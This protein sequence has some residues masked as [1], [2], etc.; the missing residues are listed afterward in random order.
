MTFGPSPSGPRSA[1][2]PPLPRRPC[3]DP[4]VAQG[5]IGAAGLA[6]TVT[7][8]R[9]PDCP[10]VWVN[11][12]FERT[13]G[14]RF[15]A[16]VGRN[17]RFLQGPDTD[18]A[19]VEQVRAALLRREPVSVTLLNYRADG[20]T[21]WNELSISAVVDEA[22]ELT[23][24]VGVQ[25]DVTA[26]VTAELD[27]ERHLRVERAAR[28]E[29]E[30]AQARLALL[31]EAT[32][33]LAATL[34]VDEAL[35]RLT[36]LAVPALAD[37]CVVELVDPEGRDHRVLARHADPARAEDL[38]RLE[39]LRAGGMS[40]GA[41]VHA[42][43]GGG[44][45]LLLPDISEAQLARWT[46]DEELRRV[47]RR[48]GFGSA[49]VVPLRARRHVVGTLSLVRRP[50]SPRHDQ[51]DFD[52]AADLARRAALALDNARLYTR[53]RMVAEELQRELL[54][55]LT[56][57]PGLDTAARYLP[58]SESAQV[59]GDW[60][61]LFALP[62]GAA[63][64]AIG[65]VMG[66]D[67]TA[68]AAMGQ[69]RS[70]LRSYAWKGARPG[71]VLDNL[72]ELVQGL[73]MAQLATAIYARVEF[74]PD[75]PA[76]APPAGPVLRLAN[77]GHL[78]PLLRTPDGRVRALQEG[79]GLLIGAPPGGPRTEAAVALPLGS[80]LLLYTDGLVEAR[81][82]DVE[83]RIRDLADALAT[84]P[85]GVKQLADHVLGVASRDRTDDLAVLAVAVR[86]R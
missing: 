6:M 52:T 12:A 35:Q 56:A 79:R 21:F 11:Q 29:A 15:A 67:L 66:H 27:R 2:T 53:E 31:A 19:A 68:A 33:T 4:A 77:A 71:Q 55:R 40:A 1:A 25:A 62:D 44:P 69:L 72:D 16:A 39:R 86:G 76:G 47:Y 54:P 28:A 37:W 80:L 23:H 18:P 38:R 46:T 17:C 85:A 82:V 24:F 13:T 60:Y 51:G 26:R 61:D 84:A 5:A 45:G 81:G 50:G 75:R 42:M 7:D 3:L 9:R 20:S 43:L 58:G 10:L 73:D 59:G 32:S 63:G 30:A 65:D 41:P 49:V 14:Y 70:V 74:P 57:V 64:L 83:D 36:E 8:A 48:L 78:P 34:D 22:G